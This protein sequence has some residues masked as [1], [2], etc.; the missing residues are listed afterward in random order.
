MSAESIAHGTPEA[1]REFIAETAGMARIQ[2]EMIETFA[3]IG[4]DAGTQYALRKLMA[5][6][7]TL[8]K[9]VCDLHEENTRREFE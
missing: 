7:K 4:D 3:S 5:Y 1:Y 8:L 2:A 6:S 9:V